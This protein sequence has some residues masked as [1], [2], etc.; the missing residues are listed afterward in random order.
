MSSLQLAFCIAMLHSLLMLILNNM[1]DNGFKPYFYSSSYR[2]VSIITHQNEIFSEL[3]KLSTRKNY[4][5]FFKAVINKAL[6]QM[7]A[8]TLG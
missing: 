5:T 1:I 3:R 7:I 6:F 2:L 8:R 4:V